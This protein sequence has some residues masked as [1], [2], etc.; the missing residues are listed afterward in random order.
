MEPRRRIGIAHVAEQERPVF[1]PKQFMDSRDLWGRDRGFI[2]SIQI[3]APNL[4]WSSKQIGNI[5]RICARH[6]LLDHR[7]PGSNNLRG[8]FQFRHIERQTKNLSARRTRARKHIKR[9]IAAE[10]TGFYLIAKLR[11]LLPRSI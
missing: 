8:I 5:E 11:D 1:E 6:G 7:F 9:V 3:E 2:L 10:T 4:R